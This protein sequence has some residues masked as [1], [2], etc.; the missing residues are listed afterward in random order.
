M[1]DR[2]RQKAGI[3]LFVSSGP[4]CEAYNKKVGGKKG[5]AHLT[6][7]AA[8]LLCSISRVRFQLYNAA[9]TVGVTRL[10]IGRAFLHVD[11]A[12]HLPQEVTWVY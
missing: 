11:I 4:R 8:D 9:R 3:P 6:G 7:E 1:L 10:G 2:L 5:S 12:T